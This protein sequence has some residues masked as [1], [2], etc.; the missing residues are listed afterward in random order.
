MKF[1]QVKE[2]V[3][4]MDAIAKCILEKKEVPVPGEMGKQDIKILQATYEAAR[5]GKRIEL[6]QAI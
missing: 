3:L 4:H 6:E 2:Q 5:S 1:G